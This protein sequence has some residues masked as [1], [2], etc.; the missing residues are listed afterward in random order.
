[1]TN[2]DLKTLRT[3]IAFTQLEMAR[4]MGLAL[5]L[6]QDLEAGKKPLKVRHVKI[7]ERVSLEYAV[8]KQNPMIALPVIRQEALQLVDMIR[9]YK[10]VP[11]R[12]EGKGQF[13]LVELELG[14]YGELVSR[15]VVPEPFRTRREAEQM[16]E[17]AAK[18][19]LGANGFNE[20]NGYWWGRDLRNR[21][22][23]FIV[24]AI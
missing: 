22:Y 14:D 4:A 5:R 11:P 3:T 16:A 12:T 6:Y 13:Q 17:S 18:S 23:R 8:S 7:A 10:A 24:E 15:K 2:E 21:V 19:H 9:G 1:M 20:E